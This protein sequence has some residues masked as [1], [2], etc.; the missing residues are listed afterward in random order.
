[1]VEH[2]P[3]PWQVERDEHFGPGFVI[4]ARG[5]ENRCPV[6]RMKSPLRDADETLEGDARLIVKAVNNHDALVNA[7]R[8]FVDHATY[9]VSTEINPR[10]YAW[11]GEG[12][13]DYAKSLADTVL[14]AVGSPR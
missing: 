6:V 12:A 5:M 1:M 2:T 14:S 13:L 11:R 9:P 3:T 4:T 7:L 8:A 10:G